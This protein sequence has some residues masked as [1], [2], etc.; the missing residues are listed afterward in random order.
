[1]KAVGS[2]YLQEHSKSPQ[3]WRVVIGFYFLW[4]R[5][6]V[7]SEIE[8]LISIQVCDDIIPNENPTSAIG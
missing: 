1:M 7:L 3:I 4:H 2:S 8:F 5:S 6:K